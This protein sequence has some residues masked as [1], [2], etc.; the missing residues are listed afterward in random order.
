MAKLTPEIVEEIEKLRDEELTAEQIAA[1][2][3]ISV[4]D[5]VDLFTV[6]DPPK[7]KRGLLEHSL[8]TMFPLVEIAK[9]TY[10]NDPRMGNAQALT[11][12]ENQQQALI[13]QIIDLEDP[14]ETYNEIM[15]KVQHLIRNMLSFVM[16]SSADLKISMER[17]GVPRNI[18]ES[19]INNMLDQYGISI[20]NVYNDIS[21]QIAEI[22]EYE[23]PEFGPPGVI[24]LP[25]GKKEGNG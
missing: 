4:E 1:Q 13:K 3:R 17:Q 20:G 25:G 19:L 10:R 6:L 11:S 14:E 5:V 12:L 9:K 22:L 21:K 2:L 16:Q 24:T 15:K 18:S 7:T 8:R 23:I